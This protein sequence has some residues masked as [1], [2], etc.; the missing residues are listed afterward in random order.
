MGISIDSVESMPGRKKSLG[1]CGRVVTIGP[2]LCPGDWLASKGL[3]KLQRT[4]SLLFRF[5]ITEHKRPIRCVIVTKHVNNGL[6]GGDE[7]EENLLHLAQVP[8][9]TDTVS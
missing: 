2:M 5:R 4:N 1:S 7:F 3:V 8:C 9:K 6:Y